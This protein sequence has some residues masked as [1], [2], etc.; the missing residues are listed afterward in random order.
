MDFVPSFTR[1]PDVWFY[2]VRHYRSEGSPAAGVLGLVRDDSRDA[3]LTL[4]GQTIANPPPPQPITK[5]STSLDLGEIRWPSAG[6]DFVKLRLRV[7]YPPWWK[8][9]KPSQLTLQMSFADGSEKSSRFVI[10]P[11]RTSDVWV[12]PWDDK[13]MGR[14][15]AIDESARRGENHP[16]RP[17]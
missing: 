8:L 11:N 9:R 17:G 12:Y 6:A 1:S 15:F 2:L 16:A 7:E 14:Y 13:E 10:E 4:A 5:R 3:R